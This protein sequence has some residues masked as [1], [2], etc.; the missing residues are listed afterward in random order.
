VSVPE[1]TGS[2]REEQPVRLVP[3]EATQDAAAA[4]IL[5]PCAPDRSVAGGQRL[6]AMARDDPQCEISG[7]Y[8]GNM[9]A[10]VCVVRTIPFAKEI[11]ALA[12]GEE[13]R[14]RGYGRACLTAVVARSGRRP[15]TV[16][17]AEDMAGFYRSCGFRVIGRRRGPDGAVRYRLG[18]HA[19]RPAPGSQRG[20]IPA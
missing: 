12:V 4:V 20:E 11:V 9:L 15:L 2:D 19:P 5:A 17:A 6:L 14:G 3:L 16:E 1:T 18:W 10:A 13:F 8:V 7:L